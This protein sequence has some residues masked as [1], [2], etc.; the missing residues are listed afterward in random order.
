M[1]HANLK[2]G[3]RVHIRMG[4]SSN[5]G[6]MPVCFNG[7]I[8]SVNDGTEIEIVAQGDGAELIA[9]PVSTKPGEG[10]PNE[11]H[12]AFM[13]YLTTRQSNYWFSVSAEFEFFNNYESKYGIEHFG[14]VESLAGGNGATN[15]DG[16]VNGWFGKVIDVLTPKAWEDEVHAAAEG[17]GRFFTSVLVDN[18]SWMASLITE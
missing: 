8:A 3:A 9:M 1:E 4:Y 2:E 17:I 11:P 18:V 10:T 6:N 5:S 12:N 16:R 13:K 7:H 15:G 14:Y